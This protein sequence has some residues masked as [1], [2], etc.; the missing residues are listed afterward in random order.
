MD[1]I[2]EESEDSDTERRV[3]GPIPEEVKE[4]I[5]EAEPGADEARRAEANND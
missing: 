3:S 4:V 5:R 1:S 2:E